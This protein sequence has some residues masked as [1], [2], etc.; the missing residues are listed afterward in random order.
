MF[1]QAVQTQA[2][3]AVARAQRIVEL[4][5]R[6]RAA[7]IGLHSSNGVALV[8]LVFELP[9]L[10]SRSVEQRLGVSRPTA[11]KLLRQLE[12]I[13][14]IAEAKA[15]PRGQRRYAAQELL[16]AVTDERG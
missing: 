1:L 5:E 13:G 16:A 2:A 10:S 11:L 8:D 9:V 3:D 12:A 14:L 6:Y 7:A 15:G 4:R